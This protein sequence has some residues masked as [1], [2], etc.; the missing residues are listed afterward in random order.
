MTGCT[1][2][3]GPDDDFEDEDAKTKEDY[4]KFKLWLDQQADGD[5]HTY[6]APAPTREV[7]REVRYICNTCKKD[8]NSCDQSE[9]LSCSKCPGVNIIRSKF[10]KDNQYFK[11]VGN[12]DWDYGFVV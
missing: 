7:R 8:V 3:D 4:E 2:G 11:G 6:S 9:H 5:D 1:D 12:A 10:L